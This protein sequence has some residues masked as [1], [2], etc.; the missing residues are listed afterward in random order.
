MTDCC[1]LLI[2]QHE[3]TRRLLAGLKDRM[4]ANGEDVP[5]LYNALALD[6]KQHFV[7]E[8]QGLFE[9]ASQ[10]RS[11]MLM[12]VEHDDLLV[13]LDAFGQALRDCWGRSLS[14]QAWQGF[15]KLQE[16]LLAHMKEEEDG[17]FPLIDRWLEPEEQQKVLRRF[18]E[19][20]ADMQMHAPALLR[21]V[22]TYEVLDT[23]IFKTIQRPI[24]Y[25]SL[26]EQEHAS[27][28]HLMLR[29]GHS[30]ARHWAGQHQCLLVLSGR[31]L[32]TTDDASHELGPSQVARLDSRL[33]FSL[34]AMEDSHALLFKIWP[35]PHFAKA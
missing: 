1:R 26:Y 16:R 2:N 17:I 7:L 34:H 13:L 14:E 11:M 30:L 32:L 9:T 31:M 35:H 33:W 18:Y 27:V 20:Q 29:A 19:L 12:E 10:Y 4:A 28:Q 8:E 24:A 22:P 6:L 21:P 15:H 23:A 3:E 25:E 5:A